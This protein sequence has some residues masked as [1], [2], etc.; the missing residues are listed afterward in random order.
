MNR[1]PMN[2]QMMQQQQQ[3]AVNPQMH[4]RFRGPHPQQQPQAGMPPMQQPN[5]N[6]VNVSALFRLVWS[7]LD[8]MKKS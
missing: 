1:G 3:Q 2:P 8:F 5:P 7:V 6:Q 4:P